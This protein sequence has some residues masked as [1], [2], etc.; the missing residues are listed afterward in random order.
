MKKTSLLAFSLFIL[1]FGFTVTSQAV[2]GPLT[3]LSS[4]ATENSISIDIAD[5]NLPDGEDYYVKCTEVGTEYYSY[6]A[7]AQIFE[8]PENF[9]QV[10]VS[11]S[12]GTAYDC[13]AAVKL[14]DGTLTR[15]PASKRITTLGA[16]IIDPILCNDPYVPYGG[17]CADP[18][19]ICRTPIEESLTCKDKIENGVYTEHFEFTC[20]PGTDKI[21][22]ECIGITDPV[23][24][25]DDE[26]VLEITSVQLNSHYIEFNV[27]DVDL[28]SNQK[29]YMECSETNRDLGTNNPSQELSQIA[30]NPDINIKIRTTV[31]PGTQYSCFVAVKNSDN[32][33]ERKSIVR[34]LTTN[35]TSTTTTTILGGFDTAVLT[36]PAS[37]ANPFPDTNTATIEGIAAL[38]LHHR[39]V[40]GGYPD[41]TFKGYLEVNR[42]EAAKFLLITRYSTV[43]FLENSGRFPD[44]IE[45]QWYV[46]YVMKAANLGIIGGYPDGY[47]RPGNTV[48]TAEFL[49]MLTKAFGLG[50]NLPYSYPDVSAAAWYAPYAGAAE[51]Y[52][53][54]PNR[55]MNLEPARNMTRNEVAVAIYQYLVNRPE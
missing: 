15:Q 25:T 55:G 26:S 16:T 14:A 7:K 27:G 28:P 35:S 40:I 53:L 46:R 49:K 11:A 6:Y 33:L 23:Q 8:N 18:N 48:N 31:K 52:N 43:E 44:V 4:Q 41:G 37:L 30:N 9:I 51:T 12:P 36:D 3:I 2:V 22:E 47:Y 5:V 45:G 10:T 34:V 13:I 54:F 20:L 50:E 38:E 24:P 42:A 29:Y 39:N 17:E 1:S 32:S 21:G 19:P